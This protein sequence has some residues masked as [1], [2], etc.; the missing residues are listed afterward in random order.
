MDPITLTIIAAITAGVAQGVSKVGEQVI[1]DTYQSLKNAIRNRFGEESKI[2]KAVNNLEEEPD[3]KPNQ[4]MLDARLEQTKANTDT[5][6]VKL[7]KQL[8][9]ALKSSSKGQEAISKYNV[10][11]KWAQ[12]GVVGDHAKVEGGINFGSGKSNT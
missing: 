3:F 10:D 12:I 8:A 1:V 9:E 4:E 6:L 2:I 7:A 5:E 11:A